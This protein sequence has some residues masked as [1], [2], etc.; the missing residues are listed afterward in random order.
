MKVAWRISKEAEDY[1]ADDASGAGAAARGG[2]W[3]RKG[4][5][6]IYCTASVSLACLETLAG[7][8][9]DEPL[10]NRYLSRVDIPDELWQQALAYTESTAPIGWDAVPPG[11]T[12]LDL[13]EKWI[14]EQRSAI[15]L[16]PSSIIPEEPN[17]LINPGHADMRKIGLRKV[18]KWTYDPRLLKDRLA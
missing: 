16:V 6:V 11:K 1:S 2:R 14:A 18:R 17:V 9:R 13:G 5:P 7:L 4:T 8:G 10:S 15:L 12:S 3:N